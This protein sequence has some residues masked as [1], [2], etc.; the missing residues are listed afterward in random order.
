MDSTDIKTE[1]FEKAREMAV[2]ETG[3]LQRETHLIPTMVR[4]LIEGLLTDGVQELED[5]EARETAEEKFAE[6]LEQIKADKGIEFITEQVNRRGLSVLFL[7]QVARSKTIYG[8]NVNDVFP[9]GI[10]EDK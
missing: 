10:P 5:R 7:G 8:L 3:E 6:I 2:A 9:E 1:T 4:Y